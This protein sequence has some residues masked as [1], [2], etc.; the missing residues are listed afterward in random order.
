MSR[1]FLKK[2]KIGSGNAFDCVMEELRILEKLD[3]PNIIYLKEIINDP[4]QDDLHVVTQY[5]ARGTL[6]ARLKD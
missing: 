5:H 2:Q 4:S 1:R 3:H 6:E